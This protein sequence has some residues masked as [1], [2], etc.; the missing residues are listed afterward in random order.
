MGKI[1]LYD[2]LHV[3]QLFVSYGHMDDCVSKNWCWQW[4][5]DYAFHIV[6]RRKAK[7][8]TVTAWFMGSGAAYWTQTLLHKIDFRIRGFIFQQL[9]LHFFFI[10]CIWR[11]VRSRVQLSCNVLAKFWRLTGCSEIG[12]QWLILKLRLQGFWIC[13]KRSPDYIAKS[14]I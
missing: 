10:R 12:L 8:C 5:M 7:I 13:M 9:F 1:T 14:A 6:G 2:T 11:G 4:K 3:K